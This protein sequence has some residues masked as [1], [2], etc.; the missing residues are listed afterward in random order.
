[1][2]LRRITNSIEGWV[3]EERLNQMAVKIDSM[4]ERMNMND[5]NI[6]SGLGLHQ[7]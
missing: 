6:V 5:E 3:A 1:M 7:S 2:D 4:Y